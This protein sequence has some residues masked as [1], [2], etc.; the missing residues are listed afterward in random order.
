[1]SGG[2]NERRQNQRQAV[3]PP[4]PSWYGLFPIPA[5]QGENCAI[6]PAE[7]E[8]LSRVYRFPQNLQYFWKKTLWELEHG[9]KVKF[10]L[11]VLSG[12]MGSIY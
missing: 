8:A 5:E 9:L 6:A 1:M 4:P 2:L 3:P 11:M 12:K 10:A 7:D